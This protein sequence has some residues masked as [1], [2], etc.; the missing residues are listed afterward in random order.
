VINEQ[1]VVKPPTVR[2]NRWLVEISGISPVSASFEKRTHEDA[3]LGAASG[4]LDEQ[5]RS[6]RQWTADGGQRSIRADRRVHVPRLEAAGFVARE[7][8]R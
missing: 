4:D 1:V 2:R 3:S 8:A 7:G 5:A 6:D